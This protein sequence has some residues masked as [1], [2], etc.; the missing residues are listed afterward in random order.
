MNG[1]KIDWFRLALWITLTVTLASQ[2][3]SLAVT[4]CGIVK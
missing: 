4:I 1:R 2:S 3:L